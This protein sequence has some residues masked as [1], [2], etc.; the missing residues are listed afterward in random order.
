M[1][2]AGTKR[3]SDGAHASCTRAARASQRGQTVQPAQFCEIALSGREA[4]YSGTWVGQAKA[5]LADDGAVLLRGDVRDADAA[6]R[7][8][9][10]VDPELLDGAF[11]ST[12]RTRVVSKTLTA[13]EYP[14]PRTIPLHS[15]MSYMRTW[16]RLIAFHSIDVADEGG[17][18][19]VCALDP[20]SAE[21]GARL[22][23]FAAKGVRYRRTFQK[24][25]DLSWQ[26]A[27]QTDDRDQV[28]AIGRRFG[29]AVEWLAD[30]VLVTTHLAQGVIV[31]EAGAPVYFNQAHVFHP[32]SL[33]DLRAALENAVG[34]DR[35]PRLSSYGDGSPIPEDL[36][37]D[38]RA[39]FHGHVRRMV[40][41]EGDILILDNMKFAHGRLPFSGNRKV[42]VALARSVSD[43]VRRDIF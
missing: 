40:W 1:H 29:I 13:T 21:L 37:T 10:L 38:I 32:S 2:E 34:A 22:D 18:T 42:H 8:L 14:S 31:S 20:V 39:V 28:E 15:E 12:P 36:L 4:L 43:P 5:I 35:L 11:W 26:T 6:E 3:V 27:F 19:T 7:A 25:F 16:P 33:G 30:G 24:R 9:G 17:E 23:D 41:R